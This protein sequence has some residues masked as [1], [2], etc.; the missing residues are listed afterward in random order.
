M[1]CVVVSDW[2]T[3]T[4]SG[5]DIASQNFSNGIEAVSFSSLRLGMTQVLRSAAV[6]DYGGIMNKFPMCRKLILDE[7]GRDGLGK[8]FDGLFLERNRVERDGT[9]GLIARKKEGASSVPKDQLE[10]LELVDMGP[11]VENGMVADEELVLLN[12][13]LPDLIK[14]VLLLANR[15]E[16]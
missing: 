7:F 2:K 11:P 12:Q 15:D 10:P 6:S 13:Y 5:S 8:N 3:P 9:G 4:G 16:E 14:R 1:M